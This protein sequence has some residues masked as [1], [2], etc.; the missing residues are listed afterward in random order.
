M[1]T[2]DVLGYT[3]KTVVL[4]GGSS[5]MGSAA[6][7]ILSDLGAQVH[8]VDMQPPTAPHMSFH[9]TDLADPDEVS[10]TAGR[11][12]E[13]G[14]IDSY[15]SCAGISHTL[16]AMPCMLVNYIGARQLIDEVLPAIADGAGIAII[17]SQAGMSWQ[18]RLPQHLELLALGDP[19]EARAWCDDRADY[20][21]DGYTTSKE[22]L[23]VWAM[24]QAVPLGEQRHIRINCIAPCP[25][26]T[27]FMI[28]TMAELGEKFFEDFPYPTLGR[29]ATPEE[30]A[31]PL[32]LLNSPLNHVV[33]GSVLYTDQGF[34][35]GVLT[36][37]LDLS[38]LLA[39]LAPE[40]GS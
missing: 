7:Q 38:T 4:T 9:A 1:T 19:R 35:G 32:V 10:A 36:G 6:T 2:I 39:G 20:V 14:P 40:E 3:G 12:R 15:F 31:W 24:H 30:Q 34:T 17:S 18:G 37:S 33:S 22:M 23:I 29:M 8:V 21:N 27:A 28:P 16:G 11:L 13:L 5:G 25:T 26:T